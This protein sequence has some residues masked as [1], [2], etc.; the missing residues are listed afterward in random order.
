MKKS[1]KNIYDEIISQLKEEINRLNKEILQFSEIQ[2]QNQAQ[3]A[4][5]EIQNEELI[6]TRYELEL[7]NEELKR[8]QSEIEQL[9]NKFNVLFNLAPVGFLLISENFIIIDAN[10]KATELLSISNKELISKEISEVLPNSFKSYIN[11]IIRK[12]EKAESVDIEINNNNETRFLRVDLK[13]LENILGTEKFILISLTDITLLHQIY[14]QLEE[15]EEKFR[16]IFEQAPIG[17][18]RTTPEGNFLLANPKLISMLGY[19]SFDELQS[20][21]LEGKDYPMQKPRELFKKKIEKFG[22]I[23]AEPNLWLCKDG[24]EIIIRESAKAV[25][26][27]NGKIKYYEGVIEDI[28]EEEKLKETLNAIIKSIPDLLIIVDEDGYYIDIFTSNESLLYAPRNELL[29]QRIDKVFS[30]DISDFFMKSIKTAIKGSKPILINYELDV[31]NGHKYFEAILTPIKL[32]LLSEKQKVIFLAR[33]ITDRKQ[34]EIELVNAN[35]E[36]DLFFSIIGYDLRDP[37]TSLVTY[38]DIFINY[39]DKL[40]PEQIKDYTLKVSQEIYTLKN[41]I[42][43]LLD[44]SKS[45]SGKLDYLPEVTDLYNLIENVI[46]IYN[47]MLKSKNLTITSTVQPKTYIYVDRFMISSV[48]RNLIS[49]AMKYSY[50][51]STIEIYVED[52]DPYFKVYVRDYGIGIPPEKMETLFQD[53]SSEIMGAGKTREPGLGLQISKN[54]I[55]KHNCIIGVESEVGKGSIFFFTIPKATQ[56]NF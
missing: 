52:I 6:S 33:D 34:I 10:K 17:I 20:I 51:N 4:E 12:K 43:N 45:Q 11:S 49:N 8:T 5:L 42:E 36:K 29:G 55:Q 46:L 22:E 38:A 30:K 7:Q 3:S 21:N 2:E 14:K 32:E 44:W 9:L 31:L 27:E 28:T 47:N 37:I 18:Y 50:A 19:S 40:D 13:I 39:F 16:S 56:N 15:S 26:D 41:L 23:N 1:E 35:Y 25:Y 54:F 48:L 24:R 53:E